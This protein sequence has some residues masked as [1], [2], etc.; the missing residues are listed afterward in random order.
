MLALFSK[1]LVSIEPIHDQQVVHKAPR[2]VQAEPVLPQVHRALPRVL[3]E[4][5]APLDF[6]EHFAHRYLFNQSL[7]FSNRVIE[8]W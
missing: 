8:H 5:P 3:Q 7:V 4:P 6:A 2:V 1:V